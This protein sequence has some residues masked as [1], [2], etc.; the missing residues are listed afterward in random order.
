MFTR[1]RYV[2][3]FFLMLMVAAI[4]IIDISFSSEQT[5]ATISDEK[6]LR[7]A[8]GIEQP[9]VLPSA[10]IVD[11]ATLY[12][13]RKAPRS[14]DDYYKNRAYDGAPPTIPHAIL[15]EGIGAK[16][17]LQ[18]HEN[19]GYSDLFK[20][21]APVTPHPQLT[22]CRQCHVPVTT[23][24]LFKGSDFQKTAAVKTGNSALQGSPPVIPHTLH[25]RE[26]CISCHVGPSAPKEIR[27]SH[28][29]RTNCRQCHARP[30]V[31][32]EWTRPV[33]RED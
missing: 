3:L 13:D 27:V 1:R 2:I 15:N 25:L 31:N 26:N 21:Y 29:E 24:S 19:G 11:Y 22:N 18:C 8:G 33:S 30:K 17:C 23:A 12:A 6:E 32:V 16:N 7:S 5:E 9:I 28:P 20:D 10:G 14:L 4:M